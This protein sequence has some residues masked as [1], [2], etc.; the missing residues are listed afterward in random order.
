MRLFQYRICLSVLIGLLFCSAQLSAQDTLFT[1]KGETIPIRIISKGS[2]TLLY[3]LSLH[4][5][6]GTQS[7]S[8]NEVRK[9]KYADGT[10]SYISEIILPQADS[11]TIVA[12]PVP[13]PTPIPIPNAPYKSAEALKNE[14]TEEAKVFYRDY[15]TAG[16]VS[17]FGVLFLGPIINIIPA[18]IMS[19]IPPGIDQLNYPSELKWSEP[20]YRHAYMQQAGRMKRHAILKN[21]AIGTV[22]FGVLA[23]GFA[24]AVTTFYAAHH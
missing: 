8:M 24:L 5:G 14:G 13:A 20:M 3:R 18:T 12:A 11:S 10:S 2:D 16:T 23:L 1:K 9:I 7:I 4:P 22:S 17:L 6:I 15:Q 21:Y 19:N